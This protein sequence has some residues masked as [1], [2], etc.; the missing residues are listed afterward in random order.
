MP[1]RVMRADARSR[2]PG[3][4]TGGVKT[5]EDISGELWAIEFHVIPSIKRDFF[6]RG[7]VFGGVFALVLR[8]IFA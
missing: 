7:V 1:P 4:R 2:S 6:V 8:H 5:Y 3:P